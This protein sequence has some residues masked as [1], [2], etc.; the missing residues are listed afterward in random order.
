MKVN[1]SEAN[2]TCVINSG[3]LPI[4]T[5]TVKLNYFRTLFTSCSSRYP[6]YCSCLYQC[7]L[8]IK[9]SPEIGS[10]ISLKVSFYGLSLF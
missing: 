5:T 7:C 9:T 2:N 4:I 8:T 1:H 6:S 3:R 10:S